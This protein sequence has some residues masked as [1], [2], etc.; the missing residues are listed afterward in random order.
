MTES[1][2]HN[3]NQEGGGP[4]LVNDLDNR[5]NYDCP[6]DNEDDD[7]SIRDMEGKRYAVD[8][9]LKRH[10]ET[11]LKLPSNMMAL[12]Q[13][14]TVSKSTQPYRYTLALIKKML[15]IMY[16]ACENMFSFCIVIVSKK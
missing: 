2:A 5:F 4:L 9:I 3:D 15:K 11:V 8:S 12:K 10:K 14:E 13:N 7:E 1:F 6:D 16:A